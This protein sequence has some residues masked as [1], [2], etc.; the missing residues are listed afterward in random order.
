[1]VYYR[2]TQLISRVNSVWQVFTSLSVIWPWKRLTLQVVLHLTLH[3]TYFH[4]YRSHD[5]RSHDF[6]TTHDTQLTSF[7]YTFIILSWD[8]HPYSISSSLNGASWH[9]LFSRKCGRFKNIRLLFEGTTWNTVN[10]HMK[11]HIDICG[12]NCVA[13]E[14]TVISPFLAKK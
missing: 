14:K 4:P 11:L 8:S 13:V 2:H 3:F 9:I 5:Q 7:R 10:Q 1:M 6:V 12:G